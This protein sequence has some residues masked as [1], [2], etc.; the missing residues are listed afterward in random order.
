MKK[1]VIA[2]I[3]TVSLLANL[4]LFVSAKGEEESIPESAAAVAAA[5]APLAESPATNDNTPIII[6]VATSMLIA[7]GAAMVVLRSPVRKTSYAYEEEML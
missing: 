3:L 1:T 7:F 5:E 6:F 4:L 2:I